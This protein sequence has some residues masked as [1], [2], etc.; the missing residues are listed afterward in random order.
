[1]KILLVDDDSQ[2]SELITRV[3]KLGNYS[4]DLAP[5]GEYAID[6]LD[7]NSYALI[8]LDLMLPHLTGVEVC[9]KLR[10]QGNT[11]P[12]LMITG[13]DETCSKVQGLDAGADDYL[14][15]PFEPDELTAR[16]RALLRRNSDAS[17]PVLEYGGIQFEPVAQQLSYQGAPIPLRPKELAIAELMLRSPRRIFNQ[18]AILD[19][20]W[21]LADCPETSTV[22]THVRSLRRALER[23][24]V[25][26]LIETCYGQGYRLNQ[27]FLDN[28]TPSDSTVSQDEL[29]QQ[30][31][32]P[33]GS[34]QR[35]LTAAQMVVRQTWERVQQTSW[36]RLRHLQALVNSLQ[37]ISCQTS[38]A[39]DWHNPQWI[40]H[41]R[42]ALSVV[43]QLKG[44]L[45]SFGLHS[46][47]SQ[48]QEI[49][50]LLSSLTSTANP[51]FQ[52]IQNQMRQL[53]E[54]FRA[55]KIAEP[56]P[57][58]SEAVGQTSREASSQADSSGVL[59]ISRDDLWKK[60]LNRANSTWATS[61]RRLTLTDCTPLNL[62]DYLLRQTPQLVLLDISTNHRN[63]DLSVVDVLYQNYGRQVS[64]LLV[65]TFQ[66][67]EASELSIQ[68]S[69]KGILSKD[70]SPKTLLTVVAEYCSTSS[71]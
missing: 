42:K 36:L 35:P 25:H 64:I 46:A 8:L 56:V 68:P 5:T 63:A 38:D 22:K 59:V 70:W 29:I 21:N 26:N 20:L 2:V 18:Q 4:V 11:T 6:L 41:H 58:A 40:R 3:L 34:Q 24:G 67:D 32:S 37:E 66:Q 71:T 16:I 13:K 9:Q 10:A 31:V 65:E 39:S 12:I 62:P 55:Q 1:M 7:V 57:S 23:A 51:D 61:Q 28:P 45:G 48:V 54:T 53:Q 44:S 49:E 60:H 69:V 52:S 15:K 50:C 14:V 19:Q 17:A 30:P 27:S 47:T 43:H 33:D